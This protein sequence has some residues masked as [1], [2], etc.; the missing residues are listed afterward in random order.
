MVR[1]NDAPTRGFEADVGASTSL[2]VL[3]SWGVRTLRTLDGFGRLCHRP[4][5][6]LFFGDEWTA[7]DNETA[8]AEALNRASW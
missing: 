1:I 8:T 3:N 5:S 6:S 2:V 4:T 7:S